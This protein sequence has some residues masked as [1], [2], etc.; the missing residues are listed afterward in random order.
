MFRPEGKPNPGKEGDC[1]RK[2]LLLSGLL[3]AS[4]AL[5]LRAQRRPFLTDDPDPVALGLVRTGLGIEFMQGQHFPLSGLEGDLTR[6]GLTNVQVGVGEFAEFQ[7]SGVIQDFLSVSRRT[8]AA[9]PPDFAGNATSDVGDLVLGSKFRFAREKAARPAIGFKFAVQLPN[10]SNES[11]LG[12]DETDFFAALLFS[13][14][15]GATQFLGNVGLAILGSAVQPNTQSDQLTYGFGIMVP[16]HQNINLVGDLH[17]RR[18]PE[19]LGN[20]S[21]SQARL[22]VQIRAGGLLWDVTGIAGLG[23]FDAD[24]GIALG[25][26]FDLQAFNRSRKPKTVR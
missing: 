23:K 26:T 18:G 1:V 2:C 8:Q 5:P 25:I 20:E 15:L 4:L 24:S 16:M 7:I 11:G 13:K 19:R 10:A 6:V 12:T 21:R 22:G 17:G 3:I 9:L 14:H